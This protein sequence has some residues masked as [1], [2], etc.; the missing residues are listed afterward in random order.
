MIPARLRLLVFAALFAPLSA[1]AVEVTLCATDAQAPSGG[2]FMNLRTALQTG[3]FISF[4]CGGPATIRLTTTYIIDRDTSI[5]G[6]GT[7]TL[8][9]GHNWFGMFIGASSAVSFSVN[10]V[11]IVNAG[12]FIKPGEHTIGR[13]H[14]EFI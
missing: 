11:H 10:G 9:G 7:V 14:G 12:R 3:G 1:R 4:N 5:D 8:D 6:G 13:A 2:K